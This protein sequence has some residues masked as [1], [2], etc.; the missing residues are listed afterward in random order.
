MRTRMHTSLIGLAFVLMLTCS[1]V[2]QETHTLNSDVL[3]EQIKKLEAISVDGR[4]IVVQTAHKRALLSMC[5]EL[6]ASLGGDLEDLRNIQAV[7]GTSSADTR[8]ELMDQ[9]S[10]LSD[11]ENEVTLKIQT[12]TNALQSRT[13]SSTNT[14]ESDGITPRKSNNGLGSEGGSKIVRARRD[15]HSTPSEPFKFRVPRT[16]A[17]SLIGSG[18][19]GAGNQP[20]NQATGST[21]NKQSTSLN[22]SLNQALQ[23]KIEQRETTKQTET[24]SVSSNSTS[25]VDTSSAGDLVNVGLNLGGLTAATKDNPKDVSSVSVTTS[26]YALYAGFRGVDPLNPGFYNRNAPWRRFSFTLGYDDEKTKG[27]SST[28]QAKIFGL[29][30]LIFNKRDPG[31]ARNDKYFKIIE[32]NLQT[33]TTAFGNLFEKVTYHVLTIQAFREKVLIPQFRAY[34]QVKREEALQTSNTAD[35]NRLGRIDNLL[36]RVNTD[37]VFMLDENGVAPSSQVLADARTPELTANGAWKKEESDF[38]EQIG[39]DYLGD[40]F[41]EK[42]KA[43]AGNAVLDDIDAFVDKELSDARIF[44]SLQESRSVLEAIENIRRA[45]QFS[46]YFLTKQRPE[47]DDEYT[48][49]A[50]F[51]YGLVNRVN[52]TLNGDFMYR[53]SKIIGGDTRGAKFSGQFRFQLTPEKLVGRN[54]LFFFVSGDGNALSGGKPV[55]HAQAKLS[56]PILNGLDLPFSLT[57]ANRSELNNKNI[58]KAQFGFAIDTSRILQALISK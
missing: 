42:L 12:L 27:S 5:K 37:T 41:R 19:V 8:R 55:F 10:K 13:V 45:P 14:L 6:K 57:Y 33:R 25:L 34:L 3:R 53:N 16:S 39:R 15:D 28:E 31:I 18:A 4:S 48:G 21:S 30:Y 54:P 11:E 29:K 7:L 9:L 20:T 49:E 44:E 32:A 56:I 1:L 38:W 23:A 46:V 36:A 52:L 47:G 2:A 22:A 40:S 51:D 24:P 43:A 58:T 17:D 50:I 26:A 35:P